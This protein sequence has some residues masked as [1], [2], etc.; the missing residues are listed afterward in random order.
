[1]IAGIILGISVLTLLQFFVTYCHSVIEESKSHELSEYARELSS[2]SARTARPDQFKR[3]RELLALCPEPGG[4]IYKVRAVAAYFRLL[5][6]ARSLLSKVTPEAAQWIDSEC[7]GCA[8]VVAVALD[9]R[10]AYNKLL[11]AQQTGE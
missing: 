11:M 7:G 4:D 6:S 3:L 10:I 9:R 8:Y 1:M 2:I 5:A